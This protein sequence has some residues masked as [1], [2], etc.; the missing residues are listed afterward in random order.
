MPPAARLSDLCTGHGCWNSRPNIQA[1]TDVIFNNKG[2]HRQGDAWAVHC[3]NSSCHNA[4]LAQ[5]SPTV[6]TNGK[7]QGRVNDPVSCGSRILLGSNN[8]LVGSSSSGAAQQPSSHNDAQQQVLLEDE[9]AINGNPTPRQIQQMQS[10]GLNPTAP[11]PPIKD[12]DTSPPP[13][14]QGEVPVD[15]EGLQPPFTPSTRLSQNFT[16]GNV[17]SNAVISHY[18]V[19]AQHGLT[20]EQ[21]VCNLKKVCENILEILKS[22]GYNFIITSGFRIARGLNESGNISQ[23]EKGQAVDLQFA[24]LSGSLA[25]YNMAIE[26]KGVV[27]YDQMLLEYGGRNPWI[28]FSWVGS[29]NRGDVKTRL[30]AGRYIDG[31]HLI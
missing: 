12:T 21:I 30:A 31:L 28:H 5:G 23:H 9:P 20:E 6:I 2:A 17:S 19:V 24:G 7:Q 26:L 25:Y 14:P 16:L 4:V 11:P 10:V 3:C 15:C 8:I 18:T 27:S 22:K 1:S 29:G 13:Q